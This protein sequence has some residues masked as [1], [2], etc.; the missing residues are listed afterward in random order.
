MKDLKFWLPHTKAHLC[1]GVPYAPSFES[2][3]KLP[4]LQFE[5]ILAVII[6]I[7]RKNRKVIKMKKSIKSDFP[8]VKLLKTQQPGKPP[9]PSGITTIIHIIPSCDN[10]LTSGI[11]GL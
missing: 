1:N 11:S 6:K 9:M 5:F 10:W 4:I 7:I 3:V 2:L 8:L